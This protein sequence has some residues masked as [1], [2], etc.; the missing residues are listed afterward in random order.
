MQFIDDYSTGFLM[1]GQEESF[2][3]KRLKGQAD[4]EVI[5]NRV[6]KADSVLSETG[7]Y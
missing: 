4:K 2:L 3:G 6:K 7:F 5:G 1:M